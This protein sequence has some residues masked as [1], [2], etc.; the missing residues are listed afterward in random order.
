MV[1]DL[2]TT[3]LPGGIP[4]LVWLN[5]PAICSWSLAVIRIHE[6]LRHRGKAIPNVK[7]S[8]QRLIG[9]LDSWPDN[10]EVIAL[11][12]DYLQPCI[13]QLPLVSGA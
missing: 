3:S 6:C 13:P 2:M 1:V 5:G 12:L 10:F 11:L 4:T 8:V 9:E 7:N